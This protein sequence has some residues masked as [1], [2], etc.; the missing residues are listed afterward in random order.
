MSDHRDD[1]TDN[2]ERERALPL[3][4]LSGPYEYPALPGET[5]FWAEK[6]TE[7]KRRFI[8]LAWED[9]Q[10]RLVIV[11]G[12]LIFIVTTLWGALFS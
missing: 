12:S 6:W 2:D 10:S 8:K 7:F 4:D 3:D 5:P 1:V 9:E 11:L